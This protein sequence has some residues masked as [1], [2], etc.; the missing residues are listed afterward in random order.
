GKDLPFDHL[1]VLAGEYKC[2]P[3]LWLEELG[4]KFRD[5]CMEYFYAAWQLVTDVMSALALALAFALEG[6]CFDNFCLDKILL[7]D[8]VGGLQVQNER[9][10]EWIDVVPTPGAFVVNMGNTMMRWTNHHFNYTSGTHRALSF[11]GKERCSVPFFSNGNPAKVIAT[12]PMCKVRKDTR[13]RPYG[14][15]DKEET[16]DPVVL[17][18]YLQ[19]QYNTSYKI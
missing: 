4:G 1:R 12:L 2:G 7:Q 16:Y 8:D 14:P 19:E 11:S 15:R 13:G 5:T 10:G 18:E 6:E 9:P 17:G 3:N